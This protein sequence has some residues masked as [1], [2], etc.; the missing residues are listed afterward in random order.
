MCLPDTYNNLSLLYAFNGT[1]DFGEGREER[2]GR[3]YDSNN[4]YKH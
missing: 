3:R 4:M 2:D 1:G